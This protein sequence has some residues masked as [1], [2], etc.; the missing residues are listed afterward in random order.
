[1]FTPG[2]QFD[3]VEKRRRRLVVTASRA[4]MQLSMLDGLRL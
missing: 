2:L 1:M 3:G 4:K